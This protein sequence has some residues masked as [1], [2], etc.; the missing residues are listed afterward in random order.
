MP[1]EGHGVFLVA[2]PRREPAVVIVDEVP[3]E[4]DLLTV[5][6]FSDRDE[7]DRVDECLV[8]E[9]GVDCLH[10]RPRFEIRPPVKDRVDVQVG[11]AHDATRFAR[12]MIAA[13]AS[14]DAPSL[15]PICSADS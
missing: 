12:E 14:L 3:G 4:D 2:P 7:G 15:H 9:S 13:T 10:I 11:E 1:G 5:G 6:R 8:S